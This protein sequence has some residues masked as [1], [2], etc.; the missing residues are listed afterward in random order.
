MT[1]TTGAV[2][3]Y[4]GVTINTPAF[5]GVPSDFF[6]VNFT[7][8]PTVSG[9]Y[10]NVG[11]AVYGLSNVSYVSCVFYGSGGNNGIGLA[12]AGSA[13]ST[14]YSI[15]HNL[16]MCSF[17]SLGIGFYYGTYIQGVT[18]S[19]CNFTNGETAVYLPASDQG[20]SQ[21]AI[22]NCQIEGTA[23]QVIVAQNLSAFYFTGN[24]VFV[25]QNCIGVSFQAQVGGTTLT[26]NSFYGSTNTTGISITSGSIGDSGV[27]VGNVFGTA[28][29]VYIGTS[30]SGWN[31]QA[32]LY[33][34]T[35]KVNNLG[36]GNSI[37]V[38]TE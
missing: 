11:L 37:G 12:V 21:L 9:S 31:V 34:G 6:R 14:Y 13:S 8:D 32:N 2:N 10:W 1:F 3:M 5:A 22:S 38:A 16:S 25:P 28:T 4:Y 7:G 36:T 15:I 30:V 17:Y 18:I 27:I 19:Q 26:G 33:T 20:E 24:L 35:T 29:G 23:N